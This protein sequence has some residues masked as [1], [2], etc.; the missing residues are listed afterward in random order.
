MRL[1]L[2]LCLLL[3]FAPSAQTLTQTVR[4]RVFDAE[5]RAP[6]VGV[7]VL[8]ADAE[9]PLGAVTDVN[10]AYRLEGVPVGRAAVR[11]TYL[12]YEPQTVPNVVVTS[13]KEVL[14]SLSLR[15]SIQQ[16]DEVAVR[17]AEVGAARNEMATVSA[18]AFTVDET[19]RYAGS[20][21]D[22]ARMA[23]S[24]AGVQGAD[25]ARNDIVIRGN[26]PQGVLWQLEGVPIPNPNHFNIPGTAGGPV[27]ILNNKVLANS[28]FF[29]GAFP[30]EYGNAVAG[31]FDLRFRAGNDERH[32]FSG[33]FGF[34]GT[35]LTAEGPLSKKRNSSYLATYRYATL[36]LFSGLGIDIGTSAV[37]NYQDLNFKLN[38]PRTDGGEWS[39]FGLGGTSDVDILISDQEVPERNIYGQND[40]DQ[41]FSSRMGAAGVT[42]RRPLGERTFLRATLLGSTERVAAFHELVFRQVT[43]QQRYQ[44]DSLV[45][46]L[47]YV[48]QQH[49]AALGV[50]AYHK[51]NARLTLS[52]GANVDQYFFDFRDSLRNVVEGT[53]GYYQFRTRWNTQTGAVLAQPFVQAKYRL[54]E[55]VTVN[56]GLH[57]QHFGLNGSTSPFEPRLGLR[58]QLDPRQGMSLGV[59]RHSQIIPPYLYFYGPSTV[60]DTP[61]PHNRDVGLIRSDHFVASYDRALSHTIRLKTEVYYQ[62]L[63]DVPVER[64]PSSFSLVNTGAGF[65][66]FFPDTLVN[67]GVGRNWGL[68]LTLEKAFS[69]GYLFLLTGSLFEARYQG[70]DGVWRDTDFN[71]NWALN[72]LLTREWRLGENSVLQTGT[73]VTAVGG[74]RY[75]PVDLAA[76]ARQREVVFDDATRN[77]LQFRDYF[78]TDLRVSYRLNRPR[79]SHEIALDLVNVFDTE[80]ILTLTYAPD[81]FDPTTSPI[82]EEYQLGFLPLFYYRVDF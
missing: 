47:D 71:G 63:F 51:V 52:A 3:P 82:R 56:G 39:V 54:N 44:I 12:G 10:G 8:L 48:F 62:R 45:P 57:A 68:E 76:S 64:R 36:A 28:D 35:E 9:P 22:P 67:E 37:P 23:A 6:L 80:N 49:R 78:R 13:A 19:D 55:A 11:F 77:T 34:L 61:Q 70:S 18:R 79:V 66:R 21:G 25:D 1:F 75:G 16:L 30:A 14:L 41:Y 40:R 2:L 33:Q 5:T 73:Q 15:E 17:A 7:N 74:R 29:T 27:T 81:T 31:V 58:W 72:A 43:P 59:G 69:R 26:S 53:P 38:F 65:S 4:G 60:G 32:E 46:L 20:R 24:F 42:Y 50:L